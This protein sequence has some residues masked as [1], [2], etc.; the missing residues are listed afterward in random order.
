MKF[1]SKE[2]APWSEKF[3]LMLEKLQQFLPLS[4]IPTA[5]LNI[6]PDAISNLREMESF[7]TYEMSLCAFSTLT[8]L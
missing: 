2:T 8:I 4:D 6:S 1:Q 3:L 5:F 7:P